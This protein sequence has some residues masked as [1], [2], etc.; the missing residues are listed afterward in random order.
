M[1]VQTGIAGVG[2]QICETSCDLSV[3]SGIS[4]SQM[5]KSLRRLRG[6]DQGEHGERML[7]LYPSSL[8]GH[9]LDTQVW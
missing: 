8:F 2:R 5:R 7:A 9:W 1:V 6:V 3:A 4:T